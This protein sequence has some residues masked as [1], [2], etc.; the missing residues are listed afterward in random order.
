MNKTLYAIFYKDSKGQWVGPADDGNLH[1]KEGI[2]AMSG[3]GK[4][5]PFLEHLKWFKKDSAE[6]LHKKV[7]VRKMV[8]KT[9][10]V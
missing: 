3:I 10:K 8:W 7:W 2:I 4:D 6:F 1:S 5:K 9:V